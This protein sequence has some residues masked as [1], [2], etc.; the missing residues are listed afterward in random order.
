MSVWVSVSR[1]RPASRFGEACKRGASC[2]NGTIVPI[3]H[4]SAMPIFSAVTEQEIKAV[5]SPE[6]TF[7]H[8][9]EAPLAS[10]T[11]CGRTVKYGAK[12]RTW[13]EVSPEDRC[14]YCV[15]LRFR[16]VRDQPLPQ[17]FDE[18]E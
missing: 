11:L 5:L 12:L 17:P 15:G 7:W 18:E 9:I 8:L 6:E 14:G 10:M 3:G 13:T 2:T 16:E 4:E 1:R